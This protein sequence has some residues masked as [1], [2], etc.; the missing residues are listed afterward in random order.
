MLTSNALQRVSA[1]QLDKLAQ[2][3]HAD[4]S[5]QARS[6]S[7]PLRMRKG[8]M[9]LQAHCTPYLVVADGL[10]NFWALQRA[11]MSNMPAGWGGVLLLNGNQVQQVGAVG[12][13][14]LSQQQQ[15]RGY[16]LYAVHSTV[17][18]CRQHGG[19]LHQ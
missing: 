2:C 6:G 3:G 8:S 17:L 18:Q 1:V 13:S 15:L 5:W 11:M 19:L 10:M 16:T 9:L 4:V 14:N 7:E 12:A